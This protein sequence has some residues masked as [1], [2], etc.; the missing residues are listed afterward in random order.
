M[1][2]RALGRESLEWKIPMST[3]NGKN[4]IV[5]P[6]NARKKSQKRINW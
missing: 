1:E 3:Y 4:I 6:N 2:K 5:D